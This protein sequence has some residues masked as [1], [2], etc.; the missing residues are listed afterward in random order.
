MTLSVGVAVDFAPVAGESFAARLDEVTPLLEAAER[1]GYAAVSAGESATLTPGDPMGFHAPNSLIMLTAVA[2]RCTTPRLIAG[3]LLLGGWPSDRLLRDLD[4]VY[5]LTGD[6]LTLT[7]G[8]G[9]RHLWERRGVPPEAIGAAADA[10]LAEL[11][12]HFPTRDR[13]VGGAIDRSARRAATLGTG[14]T[15]STGYPF[16]VVARQAAAYRRFGGDGP[17]S[18]NRVCVIAESREAARAIAAQGIDPLLAAYAATGTT[19]PAVEPT[20]RAAEL[21]IVGTV[22]DARDA[23]A[24]LVAAGITHLQLRVAPGRT[25]VSAALATLPA[26]AADVLPHVA[27]PA[28]DTD[29]SAGAPGRTSSS[30]ETM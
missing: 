16:G 27:G 21:G 9:P 15:A 23:V 2:A 6:R 10:V 12:A 14:Y 1:F 26:F 20:E 17:V 5:D 8:L 28:A 3:A 29:R 25:P 24:R 7:V 19:G 4:L 18:A 13:W 30:E 22:A 11:A